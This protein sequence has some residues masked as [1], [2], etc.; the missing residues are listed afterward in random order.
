MYPWIWTGLKT[1]ENI[2]YNLGL[3]NVKI[4]MKWT[5]F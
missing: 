3:I 2:T 1:G 5:L 4:W